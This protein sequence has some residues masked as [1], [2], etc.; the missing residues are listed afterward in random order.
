MR[1]RIGIALALVTLIGGAADAIAQDRGWL[2][3][4][5][6]QQLVARGEPSDHARLGDHF[7][8]FADRYAA[9]ARRH[10]VWSTYPFG[11]PNR[12]LVGDVQRIH[13]LRR[14]EAADHAAM[15]L[16]ELG[17]HH[18]RRA[19]GVASSPPADS[20]RFEMGE[21]APQPT[22][23][24]LDDLASSAR[25]QSDHRVLHDYFASLAEK[26]T[27]TAS[28]YRGLAAAH[29]GANRSGAGVAAHYEQLARHFRR[30]ADRA[31]AAAEAHRG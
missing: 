20:A 12:S 17:A 13:H 10:R 11:N 28:V 25:T 30:S 2:T 8:A 19:K 9:A 1:T 21:G 27:K 5:D 6:V 7:A 24:H 18:E 3:S 23:E 26:H 29:S 15:T 22:R 16:R 31:R 14:A 4:V